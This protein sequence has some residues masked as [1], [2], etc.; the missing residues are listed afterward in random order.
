VDN[1]QQN[2]SA[3]MDGIIS[4]NELVVEGIN[5]IL[6]GLS[7]L[8]ESDYTPVESENLGGG[9][10]TGGN[11]Q[12]GGNTNTTISTRTPTTV[13][14][15]YTS[16]GNGKTG[17]T[18][19]TYKHDGTKVATEAWMKFAEGESSKPTAPGMWGGHKVVKDES[20]GDL[21][22][23]SQKFKGNYILLQSFEKRGKKKPYWVPD[24]GSFYYEP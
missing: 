21:L 16:S 8:E 3:W 12:G 19:T 7:K 4:K 17:K 2:Y 6:T 22:V 23:E 10:G 14:T 5:A 15:D 18:I 11:T 1:W 20:V 9:D 13:G 24:G